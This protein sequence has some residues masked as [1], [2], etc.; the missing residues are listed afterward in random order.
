MPKLHCPVGD[1][2]TACACMGVHIVSFAVSY[3][4]WYVF[5]GGGCM[6]ARACA[7]VWSALTSFGVIG[8]SH[9]EE[10]CQQS[11]GLRT[12]VDKMEAQ[13]EE[14]PK[15]E[16]NMQP[17]PSPCIFWIFCDFMI[18]LP[19]PV[20]CPQWNVLGYRRVLTW[21]EGR[22]ARTAWDPPTEAELFSLSGG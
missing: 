18:F 5:G 14:Q 8:T 2:Q 15:H 16:C 13:L 3:Q 22:K 1:L 17:G 4:V 6:C 10:C 21:A 11:A 7:C 20:L 19:H 9:I 12:C